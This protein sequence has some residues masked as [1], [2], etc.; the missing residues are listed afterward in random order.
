MNIIP[1]YECM[2]ACIVNHLNQAGIKVSGSD[3]FF[4]GCGYPIHY[5]KGSLTRIAS[6]GYA[7]N[8]RF[9][10]QYELAYQ[11]GRVSPG[12]EPLLG[13]LKESD[14]ITIRMV[15][16]FL[17]YDPVYSQTNGASH[18]INLLD[19]DKEEKKFFIVD[20]DVPSAQTGCYS[21]WVDEDDIVGGWTLQFG[22]ILRLQIPEE[23]KHTD[24]SRRVREEANRQVLN[25]VY[26]YLNGRNH[27]FSGQVTGEKACICMLQDLQKYVEKK[28]YRELTQDANFRLRIDG[29]MGAK[30]FLLE[31]F[32]EQ[33]RTTLAESYE[34]IIEGWS[35]WHMLLLKSGLV[36]TMKN[37]EHVK[38][39][40]EELVE[41]ERSVLMD[42][43]R[44]K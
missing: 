27:R 40:M 9:L 32:R 16:D 31:K 30:K 25:A 1:S 8:F 12:K 11:F 36:P 13:F 43:E 23:L 35:R 34:E 42:Y 3:L 26:Q 37:F 5:K 22:E 21:G 18:F 7:A 44:R 2:N 14:S 41:Q 17:T 6:D 15:S 38:K 24:F 33:G 4:A 29:Y 39:R 10:D 20:G 19:Y 28:G